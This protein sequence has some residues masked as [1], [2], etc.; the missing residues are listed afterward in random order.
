MIKSI[1]KKLLM[2]LSLIMCAGFTNTAAAAS[3]YTTYNGYLAYVEYTSTGAWT[4][5]YWDLEQNKEI[6]V[7]GGHWNPQL[8]CNRP[9]Q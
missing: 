4:L 1:S 8:H 6:V 5:S 9:D 7:G 3:C 2:P